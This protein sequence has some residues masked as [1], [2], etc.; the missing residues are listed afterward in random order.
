MVWGCQGVGVMERV[1]CRMVDRTRRSGGFTLIEIIVTIS[2]MLL[3]MSAVAYGLM[4]VRHQ[5]RISQSRAILQAAQAAAVE[6]QQRMGR[7]IST[8]PGGP[9]ADWIDVPPPTELEIDA[10][11]IS[12]DELAN[13]DDPNTDYAARWFVYEARKVPEVEAVLNARDA[14]IVRDADGRPMTMVD[15]WGNELDYRSRSAR[16]DTDDEYYEHLKPHPR[17]FFASAGADQFWGRADANLS[18]DEIER[19]KADNIYSFEVD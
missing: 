7:P 11:S 13:P 15:G 8:Q 4:Q 12:E 3:V 18:A 17:P 5:S 2:L 6:Y 16:D 10:F 14:G 19:Q 9:W 1:M